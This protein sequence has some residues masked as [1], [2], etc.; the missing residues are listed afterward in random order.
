MMGRVVSD[1]QQNWELTLPY[2]MAAYR[3]TL[4][5]TTGYTPNYLM[6]ARENKAPADLIFGI[7][8]ED[9]PSS[10]DDYSVEME[11]RMKESYQVVRQHLGMTAERIK[12]RYD[13]R[14]R[15][16]AFHKGQ[17]VLY[18]NPR[19]H[20]GKQQKWQQKY[21][22]HLIVEELP[23]VNY[24]IQRSRRARPFIAHVDKLRA[25]TAEDVPKSW[26]PNQPSEY[27]EH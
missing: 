21:T 22:P 23:P 17:W 26:L 9:T 16:Q 15:P 4:H 10:Y 1:S 25:W 8:N 12:R 20:A 24:R 27:D 19:K 18:F 5:Q 3:S 11:E 13:L 7:P 6:F 14:I 2:V